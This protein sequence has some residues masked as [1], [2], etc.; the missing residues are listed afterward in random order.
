MAHDHDHD[1]SQ[2]DHDHD[3]DEAHGHGRDLQVTAVVEE[4][5]PCKKLLKVEV[6]PD[7]VKKEISARLD[8]IRRGVTLKGFRKG[9]AP[10]NRIEQ[11][12]GNAVC[13]DARDHL[14][15]EGYVKA[16]K[17]RLGPEQV[18]GEGTIENVAFSADEGLKFEVT[19]HT[20]PEFELG[21]YKGLEVKV[22]PVKVGDDEINQ[23]IDR[24]RKAR[25]EMRPVE[26]ATA[27]VEPEDL[28]SVDV[29]V[30]LSDEFERFNQAQEQEQQ[31]EL[32][33]LKEHFGQQVQLPSS[34]LGD[35]EVDD[36]AD[37]LVGLKVGEWGE[38]EVDLPEDYEVVEGRN[39]PAVL[40]IRIEAIKRLA[41]ADL[42]EEW[43]KEAGYGTL[44]DLR[45]EVREELQQ[46]VEIGRRQEVEM[47]VLATLLERVGL[48]PL[49]SDLVDKEIENAERRKFIEA[50][51]AGKSEEEAKG[52]VE[53]ERETIRR[54]V[55]RMLRFF[56][57]LD[58]VARKENVSVSD[59]DV[60]ARIARIAAARGQTPDKVRAELE[61]HDVVGQVRHDLMEEKT[62]AYLR[63]HAKVVESED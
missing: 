12:Y 3:H 47:K 13:E 54:E 36:L 17:D 14:L 20:R 61:K 37:S 48:F 34:H 6:S 26:D 4:L 60:D 19:L 7:V 63:E 57:I 2:C 42:T 9:K 40:R 18:L 52:A 35:Y 45:R 30:W 11:L 53:E 1:H 29:Q 32:K 49:P 58:Q 28:L 44:A 22:S 21:D 31:T 41:M 50:R 51:I 55:E 27:V 10:K 5:G 43:A 39:E 16:V 8:N 62:R 23:A 59:R 56:F 38:A 24:L 46:R 15:K 25:G 33:P